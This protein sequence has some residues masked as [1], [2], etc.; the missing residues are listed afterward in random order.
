MIRKEELTKIG[1][2][3]RDLI[4]LKQKELKLSF[5]EDTHTYYI[6]TLEGEMTSKFPSVSTVIKQFYEGFPELEKSL[7]MCE[8]DIHEQDKLLKEW[9]ATADYANSKGSRV[10]YLL[11]KDLLAQYGSYKDV[12]QPIYNC[13]EQQVS[14]GNAMIDAGHKFINA[15]HRRGAVLLDTEMVLGSNTLKYTGQPDKVWLIHNKEGELGF[16][17]TDWK[18]LPLDTPILTSDGWKTMGTLTNNDQV[19]DKDGNLVNIMNISKVKNKKCLKII[20]DNN[21]EIISD[22]EHRWLVYREN[23]GVIKEMVMT[24]QEIKD[25]NNS[26]SKRQ[27]YNILKIK[28]AKPLNNPEIKLPIDPYV[29]GLWLGDGHSVDAKITQANEKVWEEIIKRGY[30]IGDDLSQGGAGKSTTRTVLDLQNKLRKNLLLQNKHIPEIYLS[31]SYNQRLD[32]LR[33]LMDSDGTY[34][35]TRQS[36][37]MES[38]RETQVDYFT[39]ISSSLGLKVTKS[40]FNKKFNGKVNKCYRASFVTDN[41]N[42][43]LSRNQDLVLNL[44]KDRRTFRSIVSVEEVESVPTKCIEVDSPSSTFLCGKSLLVTHNTN[45]EKNFEVHHYTTPM[46]PPF[47]DEMDTALAHYKIQLPLYARLILDMLKGTKYEDIKLFGCIIVHLTA[48]GTYKEIRVPKKFI[49]TV[50]TMPPLPRIDEVM[51]KKE[52]DIAAEEKRIYNLENYVEPKPKEGP[53]WLNC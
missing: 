12:R 23:S 4:S 29:L 15:M 33:G 1:K 46:L 36:F 45:K 43:F 5:V 40:N 14:D 41:F 11:E 35:K 2:E 7:E 21:E 32:L 8:N 16:I 31:S 50:M 37:V 39:E 9:R 42:P 20:F 34:N 3:I 6:E 17:V 28:N 49:N 51:K 44:K 30:T 38:T 26:L 25:Y 52:D 47:E 19:Y 10:H 27:S 22:F 18:G 48:F 53:W 13:D 24:T